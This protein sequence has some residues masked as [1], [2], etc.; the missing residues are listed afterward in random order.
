M[1][2]TLQFL[3]ARLGL[4]LFYFVYLYNS[5]LTKEDTIILLCYKL[6]SFYATSL[7]L[8]KICTSKE[9]FLNWEKTA[10]S[11]SP[12]TTRKTDGL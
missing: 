3:E 11:G 2:Y 7:I 1:P 5:Q 10:N 12:C 4:R 6:P 8:G 9:T